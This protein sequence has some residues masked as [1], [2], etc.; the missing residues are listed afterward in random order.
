[1][2][3]LTGGKGLGGSGSIGAPKGYEH[4]QLSNWNTG[5]QKLFNQSLSHV[6]PDSYLS[7]LAGGDEDTFNQIEAPALRQFNQLQ[8]G[9][10][11]RFSGQGTGGQK[12]SAFQN[13]RT[14]ATSNFAQDLQSRRHDLRQQAISDLMGMSNQLLGQRP[15]ENFLTPKQEREGTDW[16]GLA[17]AGIGGV[18]GFFASGGNPLGALQGA[19]MGYGIGSGKGSNAS[20][21]GWGDN[22]G[23]N[24]GGGGNNGYDFMDQTRSGAGYQ[25]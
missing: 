9:L 3:S 10:A 5:Q 22:N 19:S 2:S 16:G 12:S 23:R 6:G 17:G 18:G 25:Y 8:G 13:A 20:F 11:S 4:S 1:M 14:A 24:N 21:S 7:K 15:F